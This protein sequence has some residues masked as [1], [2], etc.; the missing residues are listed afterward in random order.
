MIDELKS[1]VGLESFADYS[2]FL[3]YVEGRFR[4]SALLVQGASFC[5]WLVVMLVSPSWHRYSWPLMSV[6]ALML[7]AAAF[8]TAKGVS[9]FER[10]LGRVAYAVTIANALAYVVDVSP[11]SLFWVVAI[12]AIVV[13]AMSPLH[14]EPI[15]FFLCALMI[16]GSL[17]F[18]KHEALSASPE[19]AWMWCLILFSLLFG[20]LL[21]TL[22]FMD[23]LGLYR[24]N[25]QLVELAYRDSLTLINNRRA[26]M[27]NLER[28]MVAEDEAALYF[29]LLDIDDF[30]SV[31]DQY[32]HA[33]GN[34]VLCAV[35]ARIRAVVG[36][37]ACGRLG[38]EEF[39][40]LLQGD[41]ALAQRTAVHLNHSFLDL[42]IDYLWVTVSIGVAEFRHGM[43]AGQL[44]NEADQALYEVKRTGKNGYAFAA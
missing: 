15:T 38:G 14:N 1:L 20:L 4:R 33:M 39:G 29:M 6:Y 17:L 8:L 3:S 30:K 41:R 10:A 21:N 18:P 25:Q 16:G 22:Y 23:R 2:K 7:F 12:S 9:T 11:Q 19:R 5:A 13:V 35:A 40:V 32:G 28:A 37:A 27:L 31:N 44:M 26:F 43:S 36:D 24:T 34:Q 42:P